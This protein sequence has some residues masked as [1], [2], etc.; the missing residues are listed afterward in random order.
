[1]VIIQK[2]QPEHVKGIARVCTEGHKA[3]K[4]AGLK[5][6]GNILNAKRRLKFE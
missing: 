5:K 4:V 3:T 6:S 1:M 2:A